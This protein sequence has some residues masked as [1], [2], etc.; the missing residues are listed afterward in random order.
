MAMA[1]EATRIMHAGRELRSWVSCRMARRYLALSFGS[2]SRTFASSPKTK[3]SETATATMWSIL[4]VNVATLRKR[5]ACSSREVTISRDR[6][7]QHQ[8]VS[9]AK[10]PQPGPPVPPGLYPEVGQD[11]EGRLHSVKLP[12]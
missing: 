1:N 7:S 3:C 5:V 12:G 10:E 6:A 9:L 8:K 2:L 4:S 11:P